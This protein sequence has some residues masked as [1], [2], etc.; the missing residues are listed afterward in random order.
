MKRFKVLFGNRRMMVLLTLAV[1][2]LAATALIA[3]SASFTSTSANVGNVFTTGSLSV[4]SGTLQFTTGKMMPGDSRTGTVAVTANSDGG[5]STLYLQA[6]KVDDTLTGVG[7]VK[8]SS[9]L[10]V[11]IT[12][13]AAPVWDGVVDSASLRNGVAIATGFTGSLSKTYGFRMEFV[14]GDLGATLADKGADNAYQNCS[15]TVDFK[16][17]AVTD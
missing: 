15:T 3:S 11:Y 12:D 5:S 14:D 1:L 16:W 9:K 17:V 6:T 8:L 2:V 7:G 4:S 13:S 10:H